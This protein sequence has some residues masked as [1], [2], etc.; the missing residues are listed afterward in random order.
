M[1]G[2]GARLSGLTSDLCAAGAPF[3][4]SYFLIF[5]SSFLRV[6][7]VAPKLLSLAEKTS[8]IIHLAATLLKSFSSENVWARDSPMAIVLKPENVAKLVFFI[9]GEKIMLDVDLA[10]L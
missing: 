4:T 6:P 9:R 2:L 5:N 8:N 3:S 10:K 1:M 7:P